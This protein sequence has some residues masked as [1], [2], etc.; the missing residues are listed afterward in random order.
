MW[1]GEEMVKLHE[2]EAQMC[3]SALPDAA[4]NEES[5]SACSAGEH[6]WANI[7]S[8]SVISSRIFMIQVS[9]SSILLCLRDTPTAL[10]LH[11][12]EKPGEVWGHP[13][14]GIKTR[15]NPGA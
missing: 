3:H 4:G 1:I 10:M 7:C 13:Q 14:A 12:Q 8:I 15:L 2:D 6:T 5:G 11:A 9:L